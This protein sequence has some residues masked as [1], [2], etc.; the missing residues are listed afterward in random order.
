MGQCL[1][2]RRTE[3][4]MK[5]VFATAQQ[6]LH[7]DFMTDKH[8]VCLEQQRPV[9]IDIGISVKPFKRHHRPVAGKLFIGYGEYHPVFPILILH[10]L[11]SVFIGAPK[12]IGNHLMP[13]Q[14]LMH[15]AGNRGRQPFVRTGLRKHPALIK[16]HS[17]RRPGSKRL[18]KTEK[19]H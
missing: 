1:F 4:D 9:E 12:R 13:Q 10:P 17:F 15:R 19:S 16:H 8:I 14:I 7:R 11:D 2:D 6:L 5:P 3:T 18:P